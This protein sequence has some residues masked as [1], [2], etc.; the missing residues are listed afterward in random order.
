MWQFN[1]IFCLYRK[2]QPWHAGCMHVPTPS[3]TSGPHSRHLCWVSWLEW[4]LSS[5]S[6]K[7]SRQTGYVTKC[8]DIVFFDYHSSFIYEC[9]NSLTLCLLK[10]KT[11]TTVIRCFYIPLL[12]ILR[13]SYVWYIKNSKASQ[14]NLEPPAHGEFSVL[15]VRVALAQP[16]TLC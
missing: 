6:T 15:R 10:S 4:C 14:R 16:L 9:H 8:N 7:S 3:C 12:K 1:F 13:A 5:P 11:L 2:T